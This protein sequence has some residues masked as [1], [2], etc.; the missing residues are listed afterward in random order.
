M[1]WLDSQPETISILSP[2][3]IYFQTIRPCPWTSGPTLDNKKS[4]IY[5]NINRQ[6]CMRS[7]SVYQQQTR[8]S[9]ICLL[10][11]LKGG[12]RW[13]SW[14][15]LLFF[16]FSFNL[17]HNSFWGEKRLF[18]HLLIHFLPISKGNG[19]ILGGTLTTTFH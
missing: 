11:E 1:N 13:T 7:P 15:K 12:R 5:S 6:I 3:F 14:Q 16:E 19:R 4:N 8:A 17:I 2:A 18:P 10:G 9:M